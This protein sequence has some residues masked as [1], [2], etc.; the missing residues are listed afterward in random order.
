MRPSFWPST[1]DILP[2]LL[3]TGGRPAFALRV[4]LAA[5]S[6]R[7]YGIYGPAFELGVSTPR[8]PGGEE[9]LDSEK[10]GSK[11]WRS[12]TRARWRRRSRA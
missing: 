12:A 2:E 10:Y 8:E 4:A 11:R 7:S 5:T 6:P 3:Q 1:P 9:F